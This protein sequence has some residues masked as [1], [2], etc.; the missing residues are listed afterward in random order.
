MA[1][2]TGNRGPLLLVMVAWVRVAWA[3]WRMGILDGSEEVESSRG[4][5]GRYS[6][7]WEAHGENNKRISRWLGP[8]QLAKRQKGEKKGICG[9][10]VRAEEL[11]LLMTC[12]E[13]GPSC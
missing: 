2:A 3:V 7:C 12:V 1:D 11:R 9:F 10:L 13:A 5:R 8:E 4:R 6:D